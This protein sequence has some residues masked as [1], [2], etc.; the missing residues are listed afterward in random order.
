MTLRLGVHLI[1]QAAGIAG[2]AIAAIEGLILPTTA[3]SAPPAGIQIPTDV[4]ERIEQTLPTP[5]ETPRP[6]PSESP[7]PPQPPRLETPALPAPSPEGAPVPAI[8]FFVRKIEVLGSTVLEDQISTLVKSYENRELT[9]EDLIELRSAITQLYLDNGYITSGAFIPNNQVL[10]S[11]VVQIQVVEGQLERTEIR[12]LRRLRD[13]YVRSRLRIATRPPLNVRRLEES[14]QL[15]Q[16]DPLLSQVNAKLSAGSTPGRNVLQVDLQ[17]APAF[18][19]SIAG[20]NDQPVSVGSLEGS[21]SVSHDN[22]L[23][24]G[25]RL[26][27]EYGLTEGLDRYD[28][29][30]TFP[31]NPLNGTLNVRYSNDKSLIIEDVFRELGIRSQ[32]RTFSIG[33]RQPIVRSPRRE[34]ALGLFLD[35]RRSQT[36]LL[37]D[38]PFSFSEGPENG[39][40]QVTVLRFT[41]DWLDRGNN[42]VLAARSQFS[43]GLNALN[44][45]VNDLG[46]DGR[47]F[48]WLGQFQWVQQLSPRLLL[49]ARI[50]AQLTPDSLLPL[51]RFSI[52]GVGTVRGF[53]QNQIVADNGITGGLEFR[54]PLTQNPTILQLTPFVEF[55]GGWNQRLLDPNPDFIAGLGLGLRWQVIP[56]L[57]VRLDYGIPLTSIENKGDS[58]QEK[59]FYFFLRYQPF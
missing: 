24:F 58:L 42:R 44:A 39:R 27:F 47:F 5:S 3:Q 4:P 36:Y 57:D 11:G 31:F 56:G 54:I 51:E 46:T 10:D 26:A 37:D 41:Q 25:D 19:A 52:G 12:G 8:R 48:A 13:G 18:H 2:F 43:F 16:I 32:S 59:G 9:F 21:L 49:I 1:L 40:S 34:F 23:G 50:D 20:A 14:L 29:S 30:Y 35:L 7:Q 6:L 22:F 28:I 15:L 55:G 17:E 33:I 53:A 38:I 45:T